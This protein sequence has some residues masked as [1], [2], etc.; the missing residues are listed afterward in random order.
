[1]GR[2]RQR[3]KKGL[4]NGSTQGE[5]VKKKNELRWSME[6]HERQEKG[7]TGVG[8]FVNMNVYESFFQK[9]KSF[10]RSTF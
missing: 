7:I 6:I 2:E 10:R 9:K 4:A 1:M 3:H 5:Y 8:A